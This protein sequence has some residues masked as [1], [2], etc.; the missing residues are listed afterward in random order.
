MMELARKNNFEAITQL[1]E[2]L[3]QTEGTGL[4][5]RRNKMSSQFI[6]NAAFEALRQARIYSG[7]EADICECCGKIPTAPPTRPANFDE[8]NRKLEQLWRQQ[9]GEAGTNQPP[10]LEQLLANKENFFPA[11]LYKLRT[12]QEISHTLIFCSDLGTNSLPALPVI[13]QIIRRGGPFQDYNNALSAVGSL[14]RAA[15][16]ARPLLILARANADNG[17]FNYALKR[18]GPAP[19]RVMPQLAQLLDHPNPEVCRRSAEAMMQTANAELGQFKELSAEE[20]VT[21]LRQWWVSVG[22]KIVWQ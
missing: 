3:R 19:R 1:K 8:V 17:N 13:L 10:V 6:E 16:C 21:H 4:A 18:I 2:L 5:L 7:T 22:Q 15:A 20:Q 9:I 11:L 12:G 14:G